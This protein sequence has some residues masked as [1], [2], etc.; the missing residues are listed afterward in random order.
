MTHSEP[1]LPIQRLVADLDG[2]AR[3]RQQHTRTQGRRLKLSLAVVG[4]V[5]SSTAVAAATGSLDIFETN[6]SYKISE[7]ANTPPGRI[8][9]N[10]QLA[11]PQRRGLVGCG[12]TPTVTQP[13][14]VL[15]VD[16]EP[17]GRSIVFG[18]V[19]EKIVTVR[20]A[21]QDV[22]T[23][24]RGGLPGRFFSFKV[25]EQPTVYA[26]GLNSA[27]VV[28]ATIGSTSSST[29]AIKSFEQARAQ[30]H[31]SGFAPS[32]AE[33]PFTYNGRTISGEEAQKQ[34][35]I[36]TEDDTPTIKCTSR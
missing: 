7:H 26:E 33:A 28:V 29:G 21:G 5:A 9:L 14:G 15:V 25:A 4:A 1:S 10:L 34:N 24:P 12:Q 17:G 19:A 31:P 2:A 16:R 20:M 30:G 23:Q 32:A 8:C 11:D 6:A 22:D 13:F 3:R 18:L 27:G 36:C 35:L